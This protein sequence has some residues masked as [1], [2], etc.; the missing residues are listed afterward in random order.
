[1]DDAAKNEAL[2]IS[3]EWGPRRSIPY[4]TRVAEACPGLSPH[5]IEELRKLA[6]SVETDGWRTIVS[7][8][9]AHGMKE[10]AAR[11]A[12][13]TSK[14][15]KWPRVDEKNHPTVCTHGC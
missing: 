13:E 9:N 8:F 12:G 7:F 2:R 5:Q 3:M 10:P 15:T 14:R 11:A 6:G 1:V 4:D